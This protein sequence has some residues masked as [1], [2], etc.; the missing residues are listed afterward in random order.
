[1]KKLVIDLIHSGA[2]FGYNYTSRNIRV[3]VTQDFKKSPG[4]SKRPDDEDVYSW[5][6]RNLPHRV[7]GKD[8][9]FTLFFL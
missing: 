8:V 7:N 1:M 3:L 9:D 2:I 5:L 6:E 4:V